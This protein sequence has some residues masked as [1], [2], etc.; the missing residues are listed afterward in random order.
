[1]PLKKKTLMIG[2]YFSLIKE[3]LRAQTPHFT[4]WVFIRLV[5]A[6]VL[7][8]I[9]TNATGGLGSALMG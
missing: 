4:Q 6:R 5:R 1:M 2:F 7:V 3:R 8:H 9:T